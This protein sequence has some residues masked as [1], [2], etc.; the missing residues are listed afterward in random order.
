MNICGVHVCD[1]YRSDVLTMILNPAKEPKELP[2]ALRI[3]RTWCA[4]II[5]GG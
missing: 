5:L 2:T 4:E 1:E 3:R